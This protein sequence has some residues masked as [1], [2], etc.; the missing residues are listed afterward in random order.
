MT[1][2]TRHAAIHRASTGRLDGASVAWFG[3]PMAKLWKAVVLAIPMVLGLSI[4]AQA[5]ADVTDFGPFGA[6]SYTLENR[7]K[8]VFPGK[9]LHVSPYPMSKRHALVWA[10]DYCW[11]S[12]TGQTGWMFQDCARTRGIEACRDALNYNNRVCLRSCRTMGGPA[13]PFD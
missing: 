11:R 8:L 13:L 2:G 10:D 12:C 9:R 4:F 7:P 5:G 1:K 6:T 3:G